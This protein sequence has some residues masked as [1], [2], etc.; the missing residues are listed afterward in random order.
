M[1]AATLPE[2][3][4]ELKSLDPS[5]IAEI[6]LRLGR[7]KKDN[8]ELLTY[9]LFDA[10]DEQAYVESIKYE[11]DDLMEEINTSNLYYAKKGLRKILRNL[12]KYIRYSGHKQT[13]MEV[14]LHFCQA[15]RRSP[16]AVHRS[17]VITNMYDRMVQKINKVLEGLHEDLQADYEEAIGQL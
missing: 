7:F 16:I 17:S 12:N 11:I 4:K 14:L 8:K 6:C 9:L 5:E 10:Y 15:I 13:E 1:K 2:I 3:R